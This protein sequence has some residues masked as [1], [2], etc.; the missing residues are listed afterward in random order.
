MSVLQMR[1]L[2]HREAQDL[3]QVREDV[4]LRTR[5]A[6]FWSLGHSLPCSVPPLSAGG[7]IRESLR[8]HPRVRAV[9]RPSEAILARSV[10]PPHLC[11]SATT[12]TRRPPR[13]AF[14]LNKQAT[15]RFPLG[16]DLSLPLGLLGPYYQH[17]RKPRLFSKGDGGGE[18]RPRGPRGVQGAGGKPEALFC[19]QR[20]FPGSSSA[21]VRTCSGHRFDTH[22]PALSRAA[23]L[24]LL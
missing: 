10:L 14:V 24:S 17:V 4:S 1:K 8:Q 16:G 11:H 12:G 23:G 20:L 21:A 22:F 19:A 7:A 6:W 13:S 5:A 15:E 9:L 2:S 18:G 3:L